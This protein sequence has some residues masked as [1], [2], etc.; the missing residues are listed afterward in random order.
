MIGMAALK[1]FLL[2]VD[3]RKNMLFNPVESIDFNGHTGPFIQYAHARIQ[4]LL[5]KY[6]KPDSFQVDGVEIGPF[7]RTLHQKIHQ[8]PTVIA[9]AATAYDPSSLANYIFELV[10]DFST[11]Y[12]NVPILNAEDVKITAYRIQLVTMVGRIIRSGMNLLGI[13][14][15]D[16]M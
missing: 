4:S 15:P 8:Y 16:R 12:Q 5:R 6:G 9:E 14:V 11:F 13:A 1:Y 7:E 3:P 2:K 10:K